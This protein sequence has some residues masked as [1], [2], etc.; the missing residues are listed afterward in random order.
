MEKT[1]EI[2]DTVLKIFE[3]ADT[4]NL[5]PVEASNLLAEDR[6]QKVGSL[7]SIYKPKHAHST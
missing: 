5:T 2:Y 3:Y 4:Q 7:Q 6:I 1:S